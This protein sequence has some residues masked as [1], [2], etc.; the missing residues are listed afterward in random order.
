MARANEAFEI[1]VDGAQGEDSEDICEKEVHREVGVSV[2]DQ[3]KPIVATGRGIL[4]GIGR[5]RI[6]SKP[7][8]ACV[9]ATVPNVYV[10]LYTEL[11]IG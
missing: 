1:L 11:A 2:A 6:G 10:V 8:I 4:G 5:C 9:F 3:V 7:T